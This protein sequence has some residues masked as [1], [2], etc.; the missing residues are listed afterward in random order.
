MLVVYFPYSKYIVI[1][2]KSASLEMI[3]IVVKPARVF[4]RLN[5]ERRFYSTFYRVIV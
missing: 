4:Y 5:I 2:A 1:E 3:N